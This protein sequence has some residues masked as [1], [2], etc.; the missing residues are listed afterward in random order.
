MPPK[1]KAAP[2]PAKPK[3]ELVAKKFDVGSGG[4]PSRK[5]KGGRPRQKDL[6]SYSDEKLEQLI[7]QCSGNISSM[8]KKIGCNRRQLSVRIH[9]TAMLMEAM[10]D[11]AEKHLEAAEGLL[12][13]KVIVERD[14][15]ALRFYLS[16]SPAARAAGW[17]EPASTSVTVASQTNVNVSVEE[18]RVI[19][20]ASEEQLLGV[21]E[22]LNAYDGT[23]IEIATVVDDDDDDEEG[24]EDGDDS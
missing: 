5:G 9:S 13:H 16:K 3:R 22:K 7:S 17:A 20:G 15:K 8:A 2:S 14:F 11:V 1:K 10:Q 24:D 18:S 4:K 12:M 19:Q 21:L 6:A 23:P